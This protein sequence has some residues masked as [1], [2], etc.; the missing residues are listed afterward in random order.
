ME[1]SHAPPVTSG[2]TSV[3]SGGGHWDYHQAHHHAHQNYYNPYFANFM[4]H[5]NHM[6]QGGPRAPGVGSPGVPVRPVENSEPQS[7]PSKSPKTPNLGYEA[8]SD[9]RGY[10]AAA[11]QA[12]SLAAAASYDMYGQGQPPLT[13]NMN[14]VTTSAGQNGP[15]MDKLLTSGTN[16]PSSFYPW[17]K[18][19][20]GKIIA[21]TGRSL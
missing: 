7:E 19:Y 4:N 13:P 20:P 6:P 5:H 21:T 8:P 3:T 10:E 14:P 17:M 12:A 18:N 2:V 15:Q 9:I 1:A 16:G 11:L